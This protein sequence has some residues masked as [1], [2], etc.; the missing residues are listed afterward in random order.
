MFILPVEAITKELVYIVGNHEDWLNDLVDES[1]ALEGIVDIEAL[2]HLQKWKV[3]PQGGSV[4]V[5]KLTF[6][7]GDQIKGG[8]YIAK[9][10]V[11]SYERSIRFGHHHTA[12]LYTKT[13]PL[14]Y[15]LAKTGLAVPC[16]C[17]K[18]PKYGE[19]KPNRSMQGFLYGYVNNDGSFNDY[20]VTIIDAQL[21]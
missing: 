20:L 18:D 21:S 17:T 3:I 5:G 14:D 1:P 9:A 19:G 15:Q 10:A 6:I 12:Q 16:L 4:N 8:E 13:S 2:L 11:I 7:H